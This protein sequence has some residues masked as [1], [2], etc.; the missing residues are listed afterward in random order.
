LDLSALPP[1]IRIRSGRLR[2]IE[3]AQLPLCRFLRRFLRLGF[4]YL[5]LLL[6]RE[7]QNALADLIFDEL[8]NLVH[9]IAKSLD[10]GDDVA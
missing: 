1:G 2:R 7:I 10:I 6:I 5:R 9:R 4:D 3:S 8:V